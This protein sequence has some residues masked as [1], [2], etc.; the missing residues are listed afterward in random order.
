MNARSAIATYRAQERET[1][2]EL[3][4]QRP[5]CLSKVRPCDAELAPPHEQVCLGLGDPGVDG[6]LELAG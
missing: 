5:T 3:V 2:A 1:Y 4:K 6:G